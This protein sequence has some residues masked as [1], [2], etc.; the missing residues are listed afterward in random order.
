MVL[1]RFTSLLISGLR[2]LPKERTVDFLDIV[3]DLCL[4]PGPSGFASLFS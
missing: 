4:L 2:V 1:V 3:V